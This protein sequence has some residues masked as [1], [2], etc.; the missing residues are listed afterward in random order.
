MIVV[1]LKYLL[2]LRH[3]LNVSNPV[4]VPDQCK[5]ALA[6]IKIFR[7]PFRWELVEH[8]PI[9]SAEPHKLLATGACTSCLQQCTNSEQVWY[10]HI[11]ITKG[12]QSLNAHLLHLYSYF[13][14]SLGCVAENS[15][16]V[17]HKTWLIPVTTHALKKQ[18][19]HTLIDQLC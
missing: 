7:Q 4:H 2:Q 17:Y 13:P 8:A 9:L 11:T 14:G 5:G 10:Q 6:C 19:T 16:L 12:A 15:I 3:M 1:G 18:P